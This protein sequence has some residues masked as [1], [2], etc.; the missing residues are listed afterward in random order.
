MQRLTAALILVCLTCGCKKAPSQAEQQRPERLSNANDLTLSTG[1]QRIVSLAPSLTEFLFDLG[2]GDRVVGVT[3]YCNYPKAATQI[4]QVG[5]YLDPSVET[6]LRM[7]PDLVIAMTNPSLKKR[8]HTL[9]KNG[10]QV[11]WL[12]V[13]TISE[14]R[15][16]YNILGKALGIEN[17]ATK[18]LAAFDAAM[19]TQSRR[20]DPESAPPKTLIVLGHRPLVVAGPGTFPSELLTKAGAQSAVPAGSQA[21]PRWSAETLLK[22][23]PEVIIDAWM[24]D[25]ASVIA[26]DRWRTMNHISAV[27]NNRIYRLRSD[28]L[29]RPGPRLPEAMREL[30]DLIHPRSTPSK[31]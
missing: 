15:Q 18:R 29:L 24:G 22:H 2:V 8:L 28:S 23:S 30:I 11:L 12:S 27:Q 25:E 3:R 7:K 1:V 13:Q 10:I 26:K 17:K 31:H 20:I 19:A 9:Q 6:I 4:D 21:Y 16:S 14:V 5:G